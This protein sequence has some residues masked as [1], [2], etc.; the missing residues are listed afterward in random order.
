M[1][2][3]TKTPRYQ[4]EDGLRLLALSRICRCADCP[5]L[6]LLNVAYER[7]SLL[8]MPLPPAPED[9]NQQFCAPM[10]ARFSGEE[11]N[12]SNGRPRR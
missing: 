3:P 5:R 12:G 11:T 1:N 8:A 2:E 4:P 6:T 10:V 7:R 9:C